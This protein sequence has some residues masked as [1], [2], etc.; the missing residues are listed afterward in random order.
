M[1]KSYSLKKNAQFRFVRRKGHSSGSH[2][3]V[4]LYVPGRALKIGFSVGKKIGNAVCRNRLK[5]R[6]RAHCFSLLPVMKKGL[7]VF[8]AREPAANAGFDKLGRSMVHILRKQDLLEGDSPY[9]SREQT[10]C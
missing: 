5:R 8:I 1:Q 2:E 10:K 6:L 9:A 3:L 7:Y 4:L